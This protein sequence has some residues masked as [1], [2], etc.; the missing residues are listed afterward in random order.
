MNH[1]KFFSAYLFVMGFGCISH[2]KSHCLKDAGQSTNKKPATDPSQ[3]I[4]QPTLDEKISTS[5]KMSLSLSHAEQL[6]RAEIHR[7]LHVAH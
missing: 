4:F 3:R 1:I 2:H 6:S 7:A 5:E